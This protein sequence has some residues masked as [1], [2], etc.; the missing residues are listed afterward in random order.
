[1]VNVAR[2]CVS[3]EFD[4]HVMKRGFRVVFCVNLISVS[5]GY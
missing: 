1:M 2:T 5:W 3:L 4:N